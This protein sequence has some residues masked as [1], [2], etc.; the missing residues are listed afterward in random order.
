MNN[1]RVVLHD[2]TAETTAGMRP[3]R[4][5]PTTLEGKTVAL[6]DIGKIRSDEY[7]DHVAV[8]LNARG[9]LNFRIGKPTNAKTVPIDILQR[10]AAKADVVVMALAGMAGSPKQMRS[11]SWL[12]W[13]KLR[14]RH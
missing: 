14:L 8:R 2:P 13:A 9:I 4:T 6:F 10:T 5:P 3:R 11:T 12:G 7:L 1:E